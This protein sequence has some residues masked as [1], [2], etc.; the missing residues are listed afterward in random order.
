MFQNYRL[1]KLAPK[2]DTRTLKMASY[3]GELPPIPAVESWLY[4]PEQRENFDW[5]MLRND[6]MGNCAIAGP[7]HIE[8]IWAL[9]SSLTPYTP[10]NEC[11]VS[12]YS[13]VSGY[14]PQDLS[15]DRGCYLL[16]VMNYWRQRGI[17][18]R[19]INSYVSVNP[20]DLRDVKTAIHLFGAVNIGLALPASAQSQ[21]DIWTVTN[22]AL[23]G[24]AAPNTWGGH[25]VIIAEYDD[26]TNEFVCIT[27]GKRQRM[28]YDFFTT[29]CDECY[30]ALSS[31]WISQ[32]GLSPSGFNLAALEKDLRSI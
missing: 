26:V 9:N 1:G 19:R 32:S 6:E 31:N 25:C 7:A 13:Q 30:A 27:W 5:L 3:I 21:T 8:M 10:S 20:K 4:K 24:L 2:I 22:P 14:D 16:Q 11:V 28:T 12:D 15:T 23:S 17:C 29:Y 18:G